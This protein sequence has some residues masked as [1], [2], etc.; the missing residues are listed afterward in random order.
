M[1]AT[2]DEEAALGFV[3]APTGASGVIHLGVGMEGVGVN[4]PPPLEATAGPSIRA[5]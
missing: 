4:P 5:E 2:V 3:S 1:R